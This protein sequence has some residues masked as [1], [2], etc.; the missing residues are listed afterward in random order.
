MSEYEPCWVEMSDEYIVWSGK[1]I[2]DHYPGVFGTIS[3]PLKSNNIGE[4]KWM[5][6]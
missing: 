1:W 5:H 4:Y 2:S 6:P 3:V